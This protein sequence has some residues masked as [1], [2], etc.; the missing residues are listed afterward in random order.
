MD[1][2][3]VYWFLYMLDV[4]F[5]ALLAM[6]LLYSLWSYK[7]YYVKLLKG[8]VQACTYGH[9]KTY[10]WFENVCNMVITAAC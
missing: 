10:L 8:N 1:A 9:A 7:F 5:H 4:L 6:Y 2:S 3:E